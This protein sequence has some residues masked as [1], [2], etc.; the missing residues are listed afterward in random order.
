M[1]EYLTK[2]LLGIILDEKLNFK[3]HIGST[4]L[5][6]N[7]GIAALKKPRYS[8]P[9]KS[10]IATY[11]SLLR[12]LFD[13]GDMIYDEP[14]DESVWQKLES[15]QYKVALTITCAIQ[16]TSREKIIKN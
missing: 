1:K 8:L 4:I 9:R 11:K 2:K 14:H 5:K 7:R 16:G 10:L 12:P 15:V 13:Y 6:V 3:E